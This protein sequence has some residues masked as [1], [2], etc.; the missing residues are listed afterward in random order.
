MRRSPE[1]GAGLVLGLFLLMMTAAL[2]V[3]VQTLGRFRY[4]S[5]KAEAALAAASLSSQRIKAE[6][7]Q[8]LAARCAATA[9]LTFGADADGLIVPAAR[10][11]SFAA[12]TDDVAKSLGG[13]RSRIKAIVTPVAALN[14]LSSPPAALAAETA[15]SLDVEARPQWIRDEDG[16]T[17]SVKN[18]W[19]R[20][21]WT[22]PSPRGAL[23]NEADFRAAGGGFPSKPT[24]VEFR[25]QATASV[26]WDGDPSAAASTN[27]GFPV[28]WAAALD[29]GRYAPC[30]RAVF[31]AESAGDAS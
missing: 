11:T 19:I 16:R 22:D 10:W 2:M 4:A 8:D 18:A 21:L 29:Q 31:R 17:R 14:G 25:R 26:R 3:A 28:D 1:R 24:M 13:Y 23:T 12:A 7:L 20:R 27:G 15:L 30:R 9:A 6:A 5:D